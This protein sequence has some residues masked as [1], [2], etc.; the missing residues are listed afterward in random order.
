MCGCRVKK[1]QQ[2]ETNV[3]F[4]T[5]GTFKTSRE[6]LPGRCKTKDHL[7]DVFMVCPQLPVNLRVSN[8]RDDRSKTFPQ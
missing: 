7:S 4:I 2:T 6:F 3:C 5:L 1:S 8:K